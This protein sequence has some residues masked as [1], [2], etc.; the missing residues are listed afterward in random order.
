VWTCQSSW[1]VWCGTWRAATGYLSMRK[2]SSHWLHAGYS[3][4]PFK[5]Q[6]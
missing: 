4:C 2:Q 5:Y 3:R 6:A 1:H